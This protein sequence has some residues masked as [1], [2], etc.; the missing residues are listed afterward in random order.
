MKLMSP[1]IELCMRVASVMATTTLL[2]LITAQCGDEIN[3]RSRF[4]LE[5]VPPTPAAFDVE[6]G[7]GIESFEEIVVD[8]GSVDLTY[9]PQ[10][11]YHIWTAVRTRD[12]SVEDVQINVSARYVEN[13]ASV[14]PASRWPAKL[15]LVA[16]GVGGGSSTRERA[17]LRNFVD[18]APLANGKS[19]VLRA[20]VV[21]KDGRHGSGEQQITAKLK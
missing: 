7:T 10:G 4:E 19:I 9:G 14:G 8:G 16:A 18:Q 20:E 12:P 21:S 6:V 5:P 11:G 1:R 17:G 13:D 3:D 2:A 15:V